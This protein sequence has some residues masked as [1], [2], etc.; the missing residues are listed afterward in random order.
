MSAIYLVRH[1]QAGARHNYDVLS[2]L[3]RQQVEKLGD[4]F[5]KEGITPA[6]VISGRPL[7]QRE[8]AEALGGAT[9]IDAAWD[10]FDLSS[11]YSSIASR[12]L[13]DHAGFSGDYDEMNRDLAADPHKTSRAVA[14]CDQTVIRAWI[15]NR[16]SDVACQRWEDFKEGVLDGIERLRQYGSGERVVICTSAGPIAT[17][18]G[19][20]LGCNDEQVLPLMAVMYNTGITTLRLGRLG[21]SD[22]TLFTF[23]AL[24]HLEERGLRSFR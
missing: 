13:V 19:C 7:R 16:Y 15:T 17:A 21:E 11:L 8:T 18:V 14:R 4:Y 5:K 12:L 24:P 10:E 3:G 6:A 1:A 20:A 9:I 2:D 22:L 23:N